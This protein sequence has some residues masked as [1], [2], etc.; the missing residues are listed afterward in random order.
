[1]VKDFLPVK[2]KDELMKMLENDQVAMAFEALANPLHEELYKRQTFNF[3]DE[4]PQ[5]QQVVLAFDYIQ[6]QAGQGGFIQLIQNGYISLLVTVIEGLQAVDI[7]QEMV[8]LLDDVLK[9][10]VLNR[11]A[12]DKETSVEEFSK[13]YEEFK[14]FE[15][16]DTRFDALKQETMADIIKEY[17]KYAV[18]S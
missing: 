10:Y 3:L 4:L 9:V 12:L 13:L 17:L 2:S 1:M 8:L 7:A 14:E 6:N 15:A 18:M 16:L 11:E 5:V